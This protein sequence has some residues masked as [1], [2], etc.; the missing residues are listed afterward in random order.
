M[1]EP[2][3]EDINRVRRHGSLE[4][5]EHWSIALSGLILLFTGLFELPIAQRYYITELP[6]LAW[7]G[8]FIVAL[9]IHYLASI[10]FVAAAFFHVVYHGLK[11]ETG[12]IPQRGDLQQ[13]LLVLKSFFSQAEEPPF[14]KYLP[15]QRLAYLGMALIIAGLIV[16]GLIKT[17]KNVYA[18][19]LDLTLTL[20]ATW[21]HNI[22]FA[23]FFL[24][25]IAHMVA[26]VI[27]PNRPLV[28]A[29]FTGYVRLDYARE[30]H[31]LWMAHLA[32]PEAGR[33]SLAAAPG[34]VAES[35]ESPEAEP[36]CA[37]KDEGPPG[38]P[39]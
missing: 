9:K 4:L 18:P 37:P 21:V 16:S 39:T 5:F 2:I 33:P 10:V 26:I 28:R 35:P 11:G 36:P 1:G 19:Q 17:F 30:R 27:R 15:E 7:S 20:W 3:C 34:E 8:D 25:F 13:S 23:L 29:I 31:P 38:E 12:L 24:A 14:E 6:G 32:P 22:F